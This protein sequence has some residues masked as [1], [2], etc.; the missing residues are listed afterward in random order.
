M[1]WL[2]RLLERGSNGVRTPLHTHTRGCVLRAAQQGER[3]THARRLCERTHF[4]NAC[5]RHGPL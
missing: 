3:R 5:T 1:W 4:V 2:V